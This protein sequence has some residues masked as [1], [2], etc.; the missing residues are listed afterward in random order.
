MKKSFFSLGEDDTDNDTVYALGNGE[1]MIYGRGP[2]WTQFV[3]APYSC[4]TVF[5]L[6]FSG[7]DK[8]SGYSVRRDRAGSYEHH[9]D[10]GIITD[11]ASEKYHCIVRHWNLEK[12]VSFELKTSFRTE[13]ADYL[14]RDVDFG[15]TAWMIY[16]PAAAAAYND[17]PIGI[18]VCV[19]AALTGSYTAEKTQNGVLITL[20]DSGTMYVTGTECYTDCA[21]QIKS[22]VRIPF[23]EIVADAD[24]CDAEFLAECAANRCELKCHPMKSLTEEAVD[25]VLMLIKAQQ[26]KSG[27]VQAG[28]NYHLAY[29]RDQYGVSRG[30][31]D[32][33]AF[34]RARAILEFYRSVFEKSHHISNA[35]GMGIDGMFHVHENDSSE[36][37]GY[38]LLQTADYL[39]ASGDRDFIRTL[40]PMCDWALKSQISALHN[41][42]LPFNGDET[43]IPGGMLPRNAI[44]H[45]SFEATMLCVT[46]GRRYIKACREICG[47]SEFITDAQKVID[48]T[49]ELFEANFRRGNMYIANSVKRIDGLVEPEYRHGVCCFNDYFGWTTRA[50]EGWYL[51][52]EC[53]ARKDLEPN[54]EEYMIKSTLL[55]SPFI[56][57]DLVDRDYIRSAVVEYIDEFRR[58]GKLPSCPGGERNLGYDYGL[59]LYAAAQYEIEA[60]DLLSSMIGLRDDIGAWWEYYNSGVRSGTGC[61]PWESGINISAAVRYLAK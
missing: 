54:R 27:G 52:P 15:C 45:G 30:L 26:H 14:L 8:V 12:P 9:L 39:E 35:Q 59:L 48:E 10:C 24:R 34:T 42:M 18:N 49:A 41:H 36:I 53:M 7:S 32:M 46:G 55:M 11:C 31:L 37:T 2:E 3:G 23:D 21:E 17:Y 60:D 1:N 28:Y 43:Y 47:D 25:D 61:R 5:S 56:G 19:S 58:T 29:V 51:C 38:L 4:P 57:S 22:A 13:T 16:L 44:N 40:V 20:R 33:G 6:D 50:A